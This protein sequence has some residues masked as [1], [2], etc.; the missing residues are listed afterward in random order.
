VLEALGGDLEALIERLA[1]WPDEDR[2]IE[3][4]FTVD[5]AAPPLA[6]RS[7]GARP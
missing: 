5:A 3:E 2:P 1:R 6:R 7:P 4:F